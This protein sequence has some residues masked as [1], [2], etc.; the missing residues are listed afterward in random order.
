MERCRRH[1]ESQVATGGRLVIGGDFTS[2]Y[3]G[4]GHWTMSPFTSG[5]RKSTDTT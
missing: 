3:T 1:I 5:L 4:G 2:V